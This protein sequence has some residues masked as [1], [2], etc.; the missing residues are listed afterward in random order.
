[1]HSKD[2]NFMAHA[3]LISSRSF[4]PKMKV[5]CVIVEAETGVIIGEGYNGNPSCLPQ[6]RDSMESGKSGYIHAEVRAALSCK[7]QSNVR[8]EAYSTL[9][10]CVDCA[11]VLIEL[12]GVQRLFYAQDTNYDVGCKA[13]FKAAGVE[14]LKLEI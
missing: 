1:M 10:P 7:T 11:K 2:S 13:V 14:V 3:M 8:K 12:G 4:D 6:M 5:G 9:I